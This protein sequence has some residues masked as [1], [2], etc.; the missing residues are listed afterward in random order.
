MDD[1]PTIQPHTTE[2]LE[3]V[4]RTRTAR[5]RR[6]LRQRITAALQEDPQVMLAYLHGSFARGEPFRD[7]DIALWLQSDDPKTAY[8]YSVQ[9]A[10]TLSNTLGLPVD[11]Q[12]L[13]HA[14]LP[15]QY[16]VLSYGIQL[17]PRNE[18]LHYQLFDLFTRQYLDF[19]I[20]TRNT[21]SP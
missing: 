20:L 10:I 21:L 12:V 15:F 9:V 16:H 11:V 3:F 2:K 5:Q 1:S 19:Q 7:V 6:K 14:P 8:Y 17:L 13:N 18:V 4:Y